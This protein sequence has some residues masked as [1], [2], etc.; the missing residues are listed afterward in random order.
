M[1]ECIVRGLII[2]HQRIS[3]RTPSHTFYWARCKCGKE[4]DERAVRKHYRRKHMLSDGQL[5][6]EPFIR[7]DDMEED[8]DGD[9]GHVESGAEMESDTPEM[10][11]RAEVARLR[12]LSR[13]EHNAELFVNARV[14]GGWARNMMEKPQVA[15]F[16]RVAS[17]PVPTDSVR[18]GE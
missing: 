13:L 7:R 6:I 1:R 3:A 14:A 12:G 17:I 5:S 2:D 18:R 15:K 10:L 11:A 16:F 9:S 4:G 8:G